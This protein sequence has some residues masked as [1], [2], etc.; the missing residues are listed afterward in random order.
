MSGKSHKSKPSKAKSQKA[1]SKPAAKSH[2]IPNYGVLRGQAVEGKLEGAKPHYQIHVKAAGTDHRI[3][4]NVMSDQA[5]SELLFFL[6]ADFH[7]PLLAHL[8]A[9]GR[10]PRFHPRH[11]VLPRGDEGGAGRPEGR[12]R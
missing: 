7:H 4:V 8:P 9:L 2:G 1:R 5:P 12:R 3:A 6:D 10:R 11:P